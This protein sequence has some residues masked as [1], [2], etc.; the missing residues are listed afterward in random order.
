MVRDVPHPPPFNAAIVVK[1]TLRFKS[2][3]AFSTLFTATQL[4]DLLC[5]AD[6]ASSA[7]RLFSSLKIHSIEMWGPMASDL[8]PV[9]VSIEYQTPAAA[10][11]GGPNFLKSDT[12]MG[13]DQC[14]HVAAG[15]PQN[16]QA[17]MWQSRLASS[18]IVTL[19]GPTNTVVDVHLSLCLQ[20]GETATAVASAV[21]GAT[22]GTIYCRGLDALAAAS[23]VLPP[24][25]YA[26][27]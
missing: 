20:N 26:T 2:N 22:V 1:K 21:S 18:Q 14:A 7:Y 3:A 8:A 23:T 19:Q 12:S 13:A 4:L 27:I 5:V 17:A 24:V 16:S 11:V 6:T 25:S 9:T 10:G 15:P